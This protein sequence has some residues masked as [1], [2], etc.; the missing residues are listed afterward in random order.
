M[1]RASPFTVRK[2]HVVRWVDSRKGTERS[3]PLSTKA[4]NQVR[5]V[6][7]SSSTPR[8]QSYAKVT[9][10]DVE[11]QASRAGWIA[12]ICDDDQ[13]SPRRRSAQIWRNEPAS[14]ESGDACAP[15]PCMCPCTGSSSQHVIAHTASKV[16]AAEAARRSETKST[17]TGRACDRA[18]G[19]YSPANRSRPV[20]R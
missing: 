5:Y 8:Y 11:L 14:H 1:I 20:Q 19:D 4:E 10:V 12:H 9:N 2:K 7:R 15:F 17:Y 18:V 6:A 13:F 16:A 3:V